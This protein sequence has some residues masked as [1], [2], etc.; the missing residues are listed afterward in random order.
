MQ[1]VSNHMCDMTHSYL[2]HGSFIRVIW[3]N[4]FMRHDSFDVWDTTHSYVCHN[5]SMRVPWLNL[6]VWHD[7][8]I[9]TTWLI[10]TCDMNHSI[11]LIWLIH[12]SRNDPFICLTWLTYICDMTHSHIHYNASVWHDSF[13]HTL[14]FMRVIWLIHT[15]N[16]SYVWL[17]KARGCDMTH[18]QVWHDSF[19]HV[20]WLIEYVWHDSHISTFSWPSF[21][22][23]TPLSI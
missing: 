12:I 22:L 3:L 19:I 7:C 13:T 21:I 10:Y 14:Q 1:K 18:S 20:T 11:C 16:N 9:R 2:C 8:F 5:S 6:Y 15:C 23:F 4:Q 17:V